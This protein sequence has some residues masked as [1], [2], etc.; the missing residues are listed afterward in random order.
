MPLAPNLAGCALDHRYEL[1][2]VLGEGAFGR[3]Y[4][5][6][7]RRLGREV[8]VKV[9]KPWW[10]E[11]GAWVERFQREA[12]LL[13]RISDPGVVQIFDVGHAEE[14][15][16]YVA[17]LVDGESLAD[18]LRDGPLAAEEARTIAEQLC[19]ALASAHRDGVVH[20]DIKPANVLLGVDGKVKVGDFGVARLAAGTSQAPSATIAGTPRYMS[21]EQARGRPTTPATDVYSAGVVLYEMLA[22]R[23]PFVGGSPVELGLRHLQDPPPPLEEAVSPRLREVVGRALAKDPGARY[24]DGEAMAEALHKARPRGAR[25]APR[26]SGPPTADALPLTRDPA[27]AETAAG[28]LLAERETIDLAGSTRRDLGGGP[29]RDPATA[30]TRLLPRASEP[31]LPAHARRARAHERRHVFAALVGLLLLVGGA[32]VAFVLTGER[33][34]TTVPE[35]R[36]LP[37]G[38]VEARARRLHVRP[39]FSKQYSDVAAGIAIA[40]RPGAGARVVDGSTVQVMLSAGP[41]PVPVPDVV[42]QSAESAES[43]LT[44]AGLRYGVTVV[45]APGRSPNVVVRQSPAAPAN[46]PRGSTVA[47]SISETPRWRALTTFSGVDDGR[48]VAFRILGSRWRVSY[49]MA[50]QGTCLLLFI[51]EGPSAEAVKLNAGS[52]FGSFELGEGESQTHVFNS[53]PGLYRL[54]V[55]GGRDSARWSMTVDD[56]Y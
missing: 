17:E 24:P 43:M 36:R 46:P 18:R 11:D 50:Y 56:Y 23:P 2:D 4:R 35:L 44:H 7:D 48:S 21:P 34:R 41:P 52:A 40:Q 33:A 20:C 3:V 37:R 14:G 1:H 54:V 28:A 5:G 19:R 22:G 38:G 29:P 32:I 12:Q 26:Q 42:G 45:A 15:P 49:S 25:R 53:G 10:A 6:L 8:A 55:S 47:L 51:C 39:A 9:I 30:R 27:R 16:Y 13:A 31:R